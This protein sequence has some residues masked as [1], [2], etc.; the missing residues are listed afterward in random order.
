MDSTAFCRKSCRTLVITFRMRSSYFSVVRGFARYTS[1]FAQ[2]NRKNSQVVESVILEGYSW[3]LHRSRQRVSCC[4]LWD[5]RGRMF[6]LFNSVRAVC[7]DSPRSRAAWHVDLRGLRVDIFR[8]NATSS[9]HRDVDGRPFFRACET[10]RVK[11]SFEWQ[12]FIVSWRIVAFLPF[13]ACYHLCT[14]TT[15]FRNS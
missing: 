13:T 6:N 10:E 11:R 3:S 14:A 9:T 8:T 1:S 7:L 5:F 12:F 2:P 15:E 4:T